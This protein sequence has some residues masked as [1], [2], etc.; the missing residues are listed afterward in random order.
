MDG[1]HVNQALTPWHHHHASVSNEQRYHINCGSSLPH[2]RLAVSFPNQQDIFPF[3][4]RCFHLYDFSFGPCASSAS[5]VQEAARD[6]KCQA[7]TT[8]LA[9]LGKRL[10]NL[11]QLHLFALY[12]FGFCIVVQIPNVF[13]V[14][15]DSKGYPFHAITSELTFLFYCDA[16]I[17]LVFTLLHTVQWFVSARVDSFASMQND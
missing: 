1:N 12:L 4:L 7:I 14:G 11:R 8:P 6:Q 13:R 5:F 3:V 2:F 15:G 9:I 10:W 17:F 16:I